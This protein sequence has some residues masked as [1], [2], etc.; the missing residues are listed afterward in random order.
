MN[1][2]HVDAFNKAAQRLLASPPVAVLVPDSEGDYINFSGVLIRHATHEQP[3]ILG[4]HKSA[5]YA[6]DV[7]VY[8]HGSRWEPPSTDYAE[9]GVFSSFTAAV[10]RALSV[11]LEDSLRQWAEAEGVGE[12]AH[13]ADCE[14]REAFQAGYK[15]YPV[16]IEA[17]PYGE[18]T[19]LGKRWLAG[20]G[21]AE[22]EACA[23]EY[24]AKRAQ[25]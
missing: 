23:R 22:S 12:A 16:E 21:E 1:Q 7:E 17:N 11:W 6:V 20:W 19:E 3:S 18:D 8:D 14:Q 24:E 25:R 13:Q 10:A 2:V 15:L 9:C 5:G 4:I